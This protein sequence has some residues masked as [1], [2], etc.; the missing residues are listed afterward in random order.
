MYVLQVHLMLLEV[1]NKCEELAGR[2]AL[3]HTDC[4]MYL[5]LFNEA[6]SIIAGSQDSDVGAGRLWHIKTF[7]SSNLQE[8]WLAEV[9]LNAFRTILDSINH[10]IQATEKLFDG[11]MDLVQ[12][13]SPLCDPV[14]EFFGVLMERLALGAQCSLAITKIFCYLAISWHVPVNNP[15]IGLYSVADVIDLSTSSISTALEFNQSV[16]PVRIQLTQVLSEALKQIELSNAEKCTQLRD[17]FIVE[18]E[19]WMNKL[20]SATKC[21]NCLEPIP[22]MLDENDPLF[23]MAQVVEIVRIGGPA[24]LEDCHYKRLCETLER[25]KSLEKT[26]QEQAKLS[27]W[28]RDA[29]LV[30]SAEVMPILSILDKVAANAFWK[31]LNKSLKSFLAEVKAN[32]DD[33]E[34]ITGLCK[35][36][37][38]HLA[39]LKL[40]FRAMEMEVLPELDASAFSPISFVSVIWLI[41]SCIPIG[42]KQRL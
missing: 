40:H 5:D 26:D 16:G 9:Y 34:M 22:H 37:K 29:S 4:I 11:E 31:W 12:L 15:T 14:F 39:Q 7:M 20:L 24:L 32:K 30:I 41:T 23:E 10:K 8:C 28:L 27:L 25:K 35:K 38:F 21:I 6:Y 17:Q 1:V 36:L 3:N 13:E 2:V 18:L 33:Q 19:M 42:W